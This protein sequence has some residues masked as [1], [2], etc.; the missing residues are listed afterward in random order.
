M[1]LRALLL[2][3]LI[4]P[5]ALVAAGCGAEEKPELG[6][7]VGSSLRAA[8]GQK[9][10][11]VHYAV[12]AKV[13][14][15]P[16]ALAGEQ[17]RKFLS[18]PISLSA[19]GGASKDAVTLAGQVGF[20]GKSYRAE[21]LVGQ[22]ET[23]VNLLGSW[24]GDR[25]QGLSTAKQS[26]EDKAG[27]KAD[28]EELKKTLRWVYDHS[29]EVLDAEVTAGPDI[30]G[31]TWQAKGHCKADAL[32]DLAKRSGETVS[33]EDRK[34]IESFCGLAEV[35][36]VVGAED[37]L[38]RQLRIAAD[39]DKQTLTQL[40]AASDDDSAKELDR[41]SMELDIK[42]TQWGKDVTYKAPANAKPMEDIGMA[43]MG[44]MFTAMS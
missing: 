4:V 17:T 34:G 26:A 6:D 7:L 39:L 13:D 2:S 38:P 40:G 28:P 3:S 25:T 19:S 10:L 24:Y 33:A 35:T 16:S 37:H 30:D 42:L 22:S 12:T 14:A 43:L 1:R 15:T 31:A 11:K 5:C 8:A 36:Y 27:S 20:L 18:D 29:D 32:V 44:L 23:Y 9:D 21:A 41:L